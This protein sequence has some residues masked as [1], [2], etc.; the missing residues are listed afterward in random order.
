[1]YGAYRDDV[2]AQQIIRAALKN[3]AYKTKISLIYANVSES[4][5]LLKKDLDR[6]SEES[7]GQFDVH[8]CLDK[9]PEKWSGSKGYITKELIQ[10]R[11]PKPQQ[12]NHILL[13][14]AFAPL[15]AFRAPRLTPVQDRRR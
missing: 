10:E 14:G 2:F 13:C 15:C 4:D 7:G 5:I 6:I 12:G 8:Y 9:P 3:G 11:M 1:M